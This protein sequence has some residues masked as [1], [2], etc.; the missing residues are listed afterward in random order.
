M[1]SVF[2]ARIK[3]SAVSVWIPA[4]L[5]TRESVAISPSGAPVEKEKTTAEAGVTRASDAS[6]I[7]PR[8]SVGALAAMVLPEQGFS[9][10]ELR[11]KF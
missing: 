7:E 3:S 8:I 10:L 11:W 9:E 2:V 5:A 1:I 4:G 6:K